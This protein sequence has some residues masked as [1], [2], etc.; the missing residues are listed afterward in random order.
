[1]NENTINIIKAKVMIE[2]YTLITSMF[3]IISLNALYTQHRMK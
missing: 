2:K 3:I 1:M